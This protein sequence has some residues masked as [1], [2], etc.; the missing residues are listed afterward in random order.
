M[1]LDELR[2]AIEDM[3]E[4]RDLEQDSQDSQ[5]QNRIDKL[6]V[7]EVDDNHK[8]VSA[9]ENSRKFAAFI[10]SPELKNE[11]L[12]LLRDLQKCTESGLAQEYRLKIV[13][14]GKK[15]IKYG[16]ETEWSV[17]Y[18][19]LTDKKLHTLTTIKE[20]T[21]DKE[22]TGY[23][24]NKIRNAA[25]VSYENDNRVR[26]LAE[27]LVE[28]DSIFAQLG[29]EKESEIMVFLDKVADGKATLLDLTDTVVKWIEEKNLTEKFFVRCGV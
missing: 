12:R 16:F 5:K 17:F 29:L 21:Q 11:I 22:K 9:I 14:N 13:Q 1:L 28:T 3:E 25:V 7:T 23:T 2:K 6:Y 19:G 18:K 27:G 10:P 4:I 24:I 26:L 20:I 15:N 8:I